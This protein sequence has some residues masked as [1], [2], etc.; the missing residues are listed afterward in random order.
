MLRI[1]KPHLSLTK[2][3]LF[4]PKLNCQRSL[5][6]KNQLFI[7]SVKETCV[8]S[9]CF[10][11]THVSLNRSLVLKPNSTFSSSSLSSNN[12]SKQDLANDMK[13]SDK[14]LTLK[15]LIK[16]YGVSAFIV[17]NALSVVD[18]SATFSLL[19]FGGEDQVLYLESIFKSWAEYLHLSSPTEAVIAQDPITL[20]RKPSAWTTFAVAYSIHKL[21]IPIRVPLTAVITPP[22][23]RKLIALGWMKTKKITSS[24]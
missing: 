6:H 19:Y 20:S 23:S 5:F 18:L 1:A 7:S 8:A 9:F 16:K 3:N 12:E 4:F 14:K 24:K 2:G 21:L 13:V 10:N 15:E 11:K 22:F 17:Y